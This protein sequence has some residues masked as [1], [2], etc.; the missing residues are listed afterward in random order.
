MSFKGAFAALFVANFLLV[1][2]ANAEPQPGTEHRGSTV[3]GQIAS[4]PAPPPRAQ[5]PRVMLL[6]TNELRADPRWPQLKGCI[7][8]SATPEAFRACLQNAF[9]DEMTGP[10]RP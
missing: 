10:P 7:D 2:G 4:L 6:R 9:G 8:N 3:V 5:A 1:A